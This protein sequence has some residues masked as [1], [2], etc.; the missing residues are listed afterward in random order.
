MRGF[1]LKTDVGPLKLPGA[2]NA[3]EACEAACAQVVPCSDPAV[4]LRVDWLQDP[5]EFIMTASFR[6]RVRRAVLGTALLCVS[7]AAP[8]LADEFVVNGDFEA[9]LD[10][11]VAYPGYV[12]GENP[13]EVTGWMGSGGRGIN[14]TVAPDVTNPSHI[15]GWIGGPQHGINP[16]NVED[17]TNPDYIANPGPFRDNGDNDTYIAFLQGNT[18]IEQVV[19]GLVIGQQYDL[20]M[21]FNARNCC[22]AEGAPLP[23]PF[24]EVLIDGSVVATSDD[25]GFV[26]GGVEPVGD[27]NPWWSV[28][29]GELSFVAQD[30][31]ITLRL[32][33]RPVS[34]G[35]TTLLL[36]NVALVS[37]SGGE[38]LIVNGDFE[39]DVE[40]FVRWPGYI[41]DDVALR[42]FNDNGNNR[43]GILFLQ[44]DAGVSQI[45]SGLTEGEE[46]VLSLDF[47]ARNCC[48]PGAGQPNEIPM[49][50]LQ[51]DL[52]WI[53]DFPG[54]QFEDGA[55]TPVGGE[56]DWYHFE[57]TFEAPD[58]FVQL[59]IRSR[60]FAGGDATFLIDNVSIRTK[61]EA[62]PGD[63]NNDL[64]LD[65]QDID[66]LTAASAI[67]TG[68]P[69]YDVNND[70]AIDGQDVN[71][72]AKNLKG[73]WIGDAN[74]DG[75]FN[76]TD[77]VQVLTAGKYEQNVDAVWSEGDWDGNG[78]FGTSDLVVALTD[79][80]YE[81]GPATAAVPEPTGGILL[82][83][84][85][86]FLLVQCSE[87]LRKD[88]CRVPV[89]QV[90]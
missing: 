58:E 26:D 6:V 43:T 75:L 20:T 12:G 17:E 35:D 85:G 4:E 44:G 47:N 64:I 32:A 3:V 18:Y 30:D 34:G 38:N 41:Y 74:V 72:W 14:P 77:L 78:R 7:F 87:R 56:K 42:P 54:E 62:I 70:G 50:E 13:S 2:E 90:A 36:D 52:E 68:P 1:F 73:T 83:I 29:T 33:A 16:V 86:L 61:T 27:L 63:L 25:F 55:V 82:L 49:P 67:G 21:D 46:Y 79:G 57:M 81:Q 66:L 15:A 31:S 24:A 45:V 10:L 28:E 9:D 22:A 5:E 60:P 80:G 71:Y 51:L 59:D 88:G 11:W 40:E 19:R 8:V 48:S 84:A 65:V 76:T 39:A 89:R 37:Q 69:S 23:L 53:E